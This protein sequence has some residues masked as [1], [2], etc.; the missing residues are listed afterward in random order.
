MDAQRVVITGMGVVSPLGCT[1]DSVWERMTTGQSGIGPIT[2]FDST[3][4]AVHFAGEVQEFD[5]DRYVPKK[6]Q[7]RTDPFENFGLAAAK[8]AMEDSGL[9]LDKENRERIG[10]L[11]GS[12]IGGLDILQATS[13]VIKDRGPRRVSP[14]C[15][16]QLITN[17][18]AGRI[19]IEYGLQGPNFCITSACATAT[20]SIGEA[21]R[22]M[23]HGEADVLLAGGSEGPVTPLGIGGFC[24]MRALSTRNDDPQTASRPFDKDR[25][26]FVCSEGA[27]VVVME[28]LEHA[29]ARGA[30]IYCEVAG[31]GRTCDAHHITAPDEQGRGAARGMALAIRDAGLNPEDIDYINAHGTSTP[32]NDK[33]ETMAIKA[34]LGEDNA[35]RTAVSSTKSMTGHLLGAAGGIETVACALA[36]TRGVVPPTINYITPDPE[37]DLDY[38]PNQARELKVDA[39]LNN[40]L[41]FGG[42]NATLCFKRV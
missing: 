11:V 10:V 37:L 14:F 32:L 40:S 19:A 30:N 1:L 13:I 15:I 31:Y 25:D 41:G 26:G 21:L 16:P 42:H 33:C 3:D 20:H 35:R 17:I 27:G 5:I 34:A 39:C 23:Q 9:E 22:M 4:Y 24:A 7:R 38:T 6:E 12:G 29:Q 36:I 28:T 8:M 18:L 2:R